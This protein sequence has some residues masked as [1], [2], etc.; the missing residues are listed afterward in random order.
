MTAVHGEIRT[1]DDV[2]SA[3]A[4]VVVEA[5]P[6]SIALSGGGTAKDA[7]AALAARA[8]DWSGI[9]VWFGDERFVPVTDPDSNEGMARAVLLDGAQPRAIH[10]MAGAGSTAEAAALAYDALVAAAPRS[11]SCTSASDPTAT[12]RR[13]SR[14]RRRSTVT[15]R[16]VVTNGD[17][18]HPH[19]RL[20]F[21]YPALARAR[22]VVF[23][24]AG[25]EKRD[26]FARIRAGD[27][28]PGGARHR[29]A[30]PLARRPRRRGLIRTGTSNGGAPMEVWELIARESIRDCIARYNANGDSGRI[31][32]MVEVFAPD[33]IMETGSGR[34]VGRD[35]IHA[36]MSSVADRG[37]PAADDSEESVVMTP[38]QEWLARGRVPFI[39]HFTATTQID[40]VSET[41][42]KARSYYLFLTVHG[43]DHWGRYLDEFAPVDGK[44]LIT[45]RREKTD[46]AFTGGWGAA[47]PEATRSHISPGPSS[48]SEG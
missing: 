23:T 27:D 17:D 24:V 28:L 3:F 42:A 48:R 35:A 7:Y 8:L 19:P 2:A 45:H 20:T 43:L 15:D 29:R 36:F 4:D 22:L 18:L 40:V 34:Y 6:S 13:C 12:P 39:R 26:A 16:L 37:R 21:T 46:A 30:R 14:D 38:T 44:W 47:P 11:T 41:E 10:S 32:Q 9:D 31:D 25:E 5:R 33:G 1:V